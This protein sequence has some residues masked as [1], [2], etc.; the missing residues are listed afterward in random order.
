MSIHDSRTSIGRA[1]LMSLMGDPRYT[2]ADHP[3]HDMVVDMIRRGFEMVM[4]ETDAPGPLRAALGGTGAS[5]PSFATLFQD[6]IAG[7]RRIDLMNSDAR[8][9]FGRGLL[10]RAIRAES[11]TMPTGFGREG[12][13]A[14][15]FR[16]PLGAPRTEGNPARSGPAERETAQ[17]TGDPKAPPKPPAPRPP[18]KPPAPQTGTQATARPT[19]FTG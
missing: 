15:R 16:N 8:A 14:A 13:G 10:L 7:G 4:G 1:G 9:A 3:E 17:R 19:G 5:L 11:F 6:A 12:V 18:L 2:D